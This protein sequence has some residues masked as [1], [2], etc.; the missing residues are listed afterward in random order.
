MAIE[1]TPEA[2]DLVEKLG[3]GQQALQ[4]MPGQAAASCKSLA[5]ISDDYYAYSR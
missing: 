4:L 5:T 2:R 1:A 3:L